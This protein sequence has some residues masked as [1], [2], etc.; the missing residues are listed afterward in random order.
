MA[1]IAYRTKKTEP[2]TST[3]I[4]HSLDPRARCKETL[5]GQRGY[6]RLSCGHLVVTVSFDRCASNCYNAKDNVAQVLAGNTDFDD[7]NVTEERFT[8]PT[9]L[10]TTTIAMIKEKSKEYGFMTDL[11]HP[12]ASL[13]HEMLIESVESEMIAYRTKLLNQGRRCREVPLQNDYG[14]AVLTHREK[15]IG[16][17]RE[18]I[19][20]R[21]EE[22]A[23][24]RRDRSRSPARGDKS[25]H[26]FRSPR[27]LSPRGAKLLYEARKVKPQEIEV[28][29][30]AKLEELE[31]GDQ[32]RD[33]LANTITKLKLQEDDEI[34][35]QQVQLSRDHDQKAARQARRHSPDQTEE[36]F[37]AALEECNKGVLR[38]EHD[39]TVGKS[40]G[41]DVYLDQAVSPSIESVGSMISSYEDLVG[42]LERS[43]QGL[44]SRD[45]SPRLQ[46]SPQQRNEQINNSL[47]ATFDRFA[48]HQEYEEA[49]PKHDSKKAALS[50]EQPDDD[51]GPYEDFE[52]SREEKEE[53]IELFGGGGTEYDGE[54][55]EGVDDGH[56][57]GAGGILWYDEEEDFEA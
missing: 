51:S 5:E 8:C 33:T 27:S 52:P 4:D 36:D 46:S 41:T 1:S 26:D 13:F 55:E 56:V 25:S 43:I 24:E 47:K 28:A 39:A 9:C 7:E 30:V 23:Q 44:A 32:A 31:I 49:G 21:K 3:G 48:P 34:E 10:D 29:L 18:S 17:L 11:N 12:N 57:L 50:Y 40:A 37:I 22:T 2:R 42:E 19:R 54:E 16:G 14:Q 38:P 45:N 53:A 15:M 6:H 20:G 35:M